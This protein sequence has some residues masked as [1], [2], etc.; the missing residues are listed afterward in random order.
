MVMKLTLKVTF[1]G[2][3][4]VWNIDNVFCAELR[5]LRDIVGMP[6]GFATELH[7]W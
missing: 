3:Y 2:G 1:V 7:G 5:A 4:I 6:L